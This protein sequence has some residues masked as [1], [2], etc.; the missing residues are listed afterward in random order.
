ME[1]YKETE[2]QKTEI[3]KIPKEWNSKKLSEIFKL[4]SGKSRPKRIIKNPDGIM[5]FPIYG[6]N[7][8]L[9]YTDIF[10]SKKDRKFFSKLKSIS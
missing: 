5:K 9:G 3:G 8:I 10:L 6:G 2:F 4:S 1:F 7:G